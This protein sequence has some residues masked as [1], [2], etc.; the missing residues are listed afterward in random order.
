MN[1]VVDGEELNNYIS[2]M[3]HHLESFQSVIFTMD[4]LKEQL[5][6]ESNSKDKV[7]AKYDNILQSL[8]SFSNK[9][10][11]LVDYLNSLM[12]EYNEELEE[13]KS[14]FR[15]ISNKYESEVQD[16]RNSYRF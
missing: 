10:I 3:L 2:K 16:E 6:W 1:I 9:M 13:I 5:S 4:K 11:T 14:N 12:D 8:L 7:M 15:K